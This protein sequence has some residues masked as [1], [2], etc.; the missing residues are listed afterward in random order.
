M[1]HIK[2]CSQFVRDT[3]LVSIVVCARA[4]P[5]AKKKLL[6]LCIDLPGRGEFKI[7]GD[8]VWVS[9]DLCVGCG[10]CQEA[11]PHHAIRLIQVSSLRENLLD[12]FAGMKL[13]LS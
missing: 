4:L 12:Y 7:K 5:P 9:E 2:Y 13:D 6:R 1:S 3:N 11:C 10:I 8:K